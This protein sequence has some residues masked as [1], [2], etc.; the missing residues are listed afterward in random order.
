MRATVH[1]DR[2]DAANVAV[3]GVF[4]G[5]QRRRMEAAAGAKLARETARRAGNARSLAEAGGRISIWNAGNQEGKPVDDDNAEAA[6]AD[7]EDAF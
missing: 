7:L 6:L 1:G 4:R 3:L 2:E 5:E